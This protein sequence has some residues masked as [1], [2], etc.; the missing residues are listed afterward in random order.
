MRRVIIESPYAGDRELNRWYLWACL[1]DSLLR[2]EAPF[3][4]H[5][6]YTLPTVLDDAVAEERELGINAGFSWR[7][8]A[9]AT[10]VYEDLGISRGMEMGINHARAMN[11]TVEFRS[12]H[13]WK[14]ALNANR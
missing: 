11:Q 4:S 10:V 2:G 7:S 14:D 5:A 6:L 9:D 12:L 3:A 8:S 1:R 13:A